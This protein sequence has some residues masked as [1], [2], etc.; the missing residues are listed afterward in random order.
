MIFR[1]L[2]TPSV[3][4][5]F[6]SSLVMTMWIFRLVVKLAIKKDIV[7]CPNARKL[8]K[9]PVPVMGG[10]AVYFGVIA[11]AGLTSMVFDTSI[12][13]S[14]IVALTVMM[15]FGLMDDSIGLPPVLRIIVEAILVFF[16]IRMDGVNFNSLQGI[17]GIWNIPTWCAYLLSAFAGVGIINAINMIDGVDGLSSG[18]CILACVAFGCVFKLSHD[19][20]MAVIAALGAGALIPFFFHNIFGRSSKMFIGDSGTMMMGM[21]MTILL[22]HLMDR[23]SLVVQNFQNMGVGAFALSILSVPVFDTLRVM[24]GRIMKGVSPFHADKSHLHHL[25]IEI[26][27]S[28]VGTAIMVISLDFLCFL[29]WLASYQI[30]RATVTEQFLVVALVGFAN[31]T[32]FYYTVRRMDH[33]RIFYR[34]LASMARHSHVETK[35]WFL[36]VRK[37]IDKI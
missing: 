26:G 36:K 11:G 28:H 23:S 5:P 10:F 34:L 4:I 33:R 8:Q 18:F 24:T 17:F 16:I 19:G 31:T 6:F 32:G 12:L 29:I 3:L 27:F 7:D 37:T 9:T 13:F 35:P 14:T 2:F 30:F 22:L 25:F 1:Q 20:T 21:L 15:Y